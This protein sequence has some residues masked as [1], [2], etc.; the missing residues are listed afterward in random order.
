MK[1]GIIGFVNK[2][3]IKKV[4]KKILSNY[5]NKNQFYVYKGIFQRQPN[6]QV[7][8]LSTIFKNC[9]LIVS[10]G[11]DG[12]VLALS[13]ELK[14]KTIPI[15]PVKIG[16]LGFLTQFTEEEFFKNFN[17]IIKGK[18][19][20]IEKRMMLKGCLH[21]PDR[22][23]PFCGLNE[24]VI[25]KSSKSRMLTM[26]VKIDGNFLT[27]L[28]ADGL[29]IS[30]PTGSTGHSLS[31]GGPIIHPAHDLFLLTPICAH[32]LTNRPIVVPSKAKIEISIITKFSDVFLTI[33]GQVN[34]QINEDDRV[35]IT[36][37]NHR[38]HLVRQKDKDFFS[39]LRA[40][41][42]WGMEVKK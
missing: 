17:R 34:Y 42:G 3:R 26:D 15:I 27:H 23:I 19:Y 20:I 37:S 31:A 8:D 30:T 5:S 41:L 10:L 4:L 33:D 21:N 39:I 32:M 22:D 14:G 12:T 13:R 28:P 2:P 18:G 29:I 40:K 1:I 38:I 35:T 11:G 6:Y 25:S 24:V 16:G 7:H 9:K 36:K